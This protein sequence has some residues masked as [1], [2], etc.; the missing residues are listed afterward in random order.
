[1]LSVVVDDVQGYEF[2]FQK[3]LRASDVSSLGRIVLPKVI[4]ISTF[5][6]G[7]HK[8]NSEFS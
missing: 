7:G 1:M 8:V 3:E 4:F 5:F 2:L 6:F